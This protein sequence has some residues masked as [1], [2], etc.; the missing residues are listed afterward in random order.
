MRYALIENGVVANIIEADG[1]LPGITMVPDDGTA[2]IGGTYVDGVFTPPVMVRDIKSEIAALES[3]ITPRRLREAVL[4]TDAGW[5][6]T[7][8]AQIAAL[9]AQ[10]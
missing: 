4:G 7:L 5:M 6:A 9:R 2:H 3:T 1:C 8:D 10:L